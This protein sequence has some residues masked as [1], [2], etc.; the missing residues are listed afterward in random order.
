[1]LRPCGVVKLRNIF[2]KI[3]VFND[4][5]NAVFCKAKDGISCYKRRLFVELMGL[6]SLI[7]LMG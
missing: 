4:L 3:L 2:H 5:R 1:M 6:M 7:S